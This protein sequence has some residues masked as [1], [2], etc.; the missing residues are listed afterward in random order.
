[1]YDV[2][3]KRRA[4]RIRV[5]LRAHYRSDGLALEGRV[6]DLSRNGLFMRSAYLDELGTPVSVD[7][8]LPG[9]G[10]CLQL[11]GEVVRVDTTPLG[12]GMGIRF[13]GLETRVCRDL[14]NLVIERSYQPG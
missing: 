11:L 8:E 1:M 3:E 13:G 6:C 5:N 2:A 10:A 14:A 12:A 4:E 7:L 9:Q